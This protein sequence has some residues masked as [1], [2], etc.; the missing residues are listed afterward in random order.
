VF[1]HNNIPDTQR[2]DECHNGT[3]A[4]GTIDKTNPPHIPITEDCRACHNTTAFAGAKFNHDGIDSGC[5]DCHNGDTAIGK[6]NDHVPTNQDC[7]VCHQTTGFVPGTFD[8][9]QNQIVDN[10]ESCHNDVF[11]TGKS[12]GHVATNADCGVCHN[13]STFTGATFDHNTIGNQLCAD[14]HAADKPQ[15]HVPTSATQD[16]GDCHTTATFV[17]GT[18]DHSEVNAQQDPN[19]LGCHDGE[20]ATGQPSQGHFDTGGVDCDACH[21]TTGW[22][23]QGTFDHCP[24]TDANFNTCSDNDYPGDHKP[25]KAACIACHKDNTAVIASFRNSQYHPFCA[26]C[27]AGDFEPEGDHN[28]GKSGTVEQNKDCSGGG[29]GCHKVDK[30]GF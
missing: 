15:N 22:G 9:A 5:V 11:A 14:C 10:C 26:A 23:D 28:G 6:H 12:T 7:Y 17:G 4:T 25:G 16:C 2:C 30:D 27:H 3:D 8:H 18:C 20:I 21:T 13:T 24:G 19:C 1:D 29:S